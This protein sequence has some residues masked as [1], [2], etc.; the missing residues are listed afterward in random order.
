M[1]HDHVAGQAKF[2]R[3][4]APPNQ[5]PLTPDCTVQD[6]Q[7]ILCASRTHI[8][9]WDIHDEKWSAEI[10]T[11]DSSAVANVDFTPTHDE[12][13]AF[14]EFNTQLTI[15]SLKSGEQRVIKSPKFAGLN[16]FGFRP[17]TGQL[18]VLLKND[19]ND[20]LTL[21]ETETYDVITAVTLPTADAQGLKWSPNGAWIAIWE[22]AA[23]GTKLAIYTADAQHYR[24]YAEPLNDSKLGVK[25]VEWSPDSLF[26]AIGKHDATVDFINSTTVCL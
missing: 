13:I 21:H 5:L 14:S 8:S 24:T 25:V 12:L 1:L 6:S 4:S 9:V 19:A 18:A 23:A 2:L 7:R 10:E 22:S 3:W 16:G 15:F 17:A 26:L 11:A 20:T